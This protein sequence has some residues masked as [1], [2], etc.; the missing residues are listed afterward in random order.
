[1]KSTATLLATSIFD[2]P[3]RRRV[4]SNGWRIEP[5]TSMQRAM[6]TP[7]VAS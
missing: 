2:S 5:E 6:S 4:G 3:A 7:R 1:M